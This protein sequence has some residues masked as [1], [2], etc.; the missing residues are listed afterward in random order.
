MN[1]QIEGFGTGNIY[2]IPTSEVNDAYYFFIPQTE[3]DNDQ[4]I[5]IYDAD[6]NRILL[7]PKDKNL[8]GK[9]KTQKVND[10]E[11]EILLDELIFRKDNE[12]IQTNGQSSIRFDIIEINDNWIEFRLGG[13]HIVLPR[14]LMREIDIRSQEITGNLP[15][16]QEIVD[17]DSSLPQDYVPDDL[18]KIDQRWNYHT[19][20][21]P[22]YLRRYVVY[23]LEQMLKN[24]EEQGIHIRVFSA[25]RSYKKQRYLYLQELNRSGKNQNSV[26]KPGHS[27]H[28]LGTA[29]DLCGLNPVSVL[30]HNFTLTNESQWLKKNAQR[31]G[32]YQSYTEENQPETGYMPEPWHYRY[33]EGRR[34]NNT[35]LLLKPCL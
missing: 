17:K 22:K 26:A 14:H 16:G 34:T 29:V 19:P 9:I 20:D 8:A 33:R 4:N 7:F 27:E 2:P 10:E 1:Q 28:Q 11:W 6:L 5:Y 23:K 30:N 35:L 15:L 24:A 3:N 13:R 18:V 12:A 32:F 21:Y 25:Y 31:F